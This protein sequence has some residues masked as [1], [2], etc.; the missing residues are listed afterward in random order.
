MTPQQSE[1][2]VRVQ[3]LAVAVAVGAEEQGVDSG[4]EVVRER[5]AVT[6]AEHGVHA[7]HVFAL[8]PDV[9]SA[10]LVDHF[11]GSWPRAALALGSSVTRNHIERQWPLGLH[12]PVACF[13][14]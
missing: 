3:L 4:V 13:G 6:V 2:L 9:E 12:R 5:L 10:V 14:I 7:G 8:R 1:R 11:A